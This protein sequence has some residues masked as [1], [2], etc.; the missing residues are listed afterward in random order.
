MANLPDSNYVPVY[1]KYALSG[2]LHHAKSVIVGTYSWDVTMQKH[3][4][5]KGHFKVSAELCHGWYVEGVTFYGL[6]I[7]PYPYASHDYCH[8][9]SL[10]FPLDGVEVS[11]ATLVTEPIALE[12]DPFDYKT[13][14]AHIYATTPTQTYHNY[15][16]KFDKWLAASAEKLKQQKESANQACVVD[17]DF[18]ADDLVDPEEEEE[19]A[20]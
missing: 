3:P 9:V 18:T 16:S 5:M 6:P 4:A 10:E 8:K 19:E 12:S 1:L 11:F 13:G 2:L 14:Y 17:D 20:A 15:Y 7:Q